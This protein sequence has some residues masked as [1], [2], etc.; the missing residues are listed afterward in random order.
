MKRR[1]VNRMTSA[2]LRRFVL[3][4]AAKISGMNGEAEDI[5]KVKADEVEASEFADSLEQDIDM[6]KA[7]KIQEAK[8]RREHKRN[9]RRIRK[10]REARQKARRKILRQLK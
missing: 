5:E 2:E 4:E 7:M 3:R 8:L 1:K 10:L 6:Y 9:V